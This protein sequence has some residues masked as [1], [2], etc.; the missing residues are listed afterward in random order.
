MN[1][2]NNKIYFN[3]NYLVKYNISVGYIL[4]QIFEVIEVREFPYFLTV[5]ASDGEFVRDKINPINN[6]KVFLLI[7]HDTKR[8]WT[9]NGIYSS[10]KLQVYGGILANMLRKQLRMFYRIYSLNRYAEEDKEFQEILN[11]PLGPGRAKTI[12]KDDFEKPSEQSTVG[13][14]AIKQPRLNKVR[15]EIKNYPI[16]EHLNR[17]FLILGGNIYSEEEIPESFLKEEKVNVEPIKMGRLNNGFTF[18]NDRNYSVRMIVRDKSLQGVELF[19]KKHEKVQTLNLKV[20]TILEEKY[21]KPGKIESLF[22]AFQIPESLPS[23]AFTDRKNI[24][25][26]TDSS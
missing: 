6:H 11:K 3:E 19:V 13:N 24:E 20:P 14:I 4:I 8:I 23:E 16:P 17:I 26:N 25:P 2:K 12:D 5:D 21:N 15:E 1:L 7:D 10:L 9:Y 18:F 22:K